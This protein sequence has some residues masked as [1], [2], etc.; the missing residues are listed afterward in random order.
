MFTFLDQDQFEI[1][2]YFSEFDNLIES[3]KIEYCRFKYLTKL[4]SY[5]L[6]TRKIY[7]WTIFRNNCTFSS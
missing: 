2:K 6:L 4:G 7:R 3:L 5:V 1:K